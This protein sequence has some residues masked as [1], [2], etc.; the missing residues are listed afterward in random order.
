[1]GTLRT[2]LDKLKG[3]FPSFE[4]G[5]TVTLSFDPARG[6]VLT[7]KGGEI[8]VIEGKDFSDALFKV[9]LGT[10]PVDDNLMD[11]MLGK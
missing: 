4:K 7:G 2:R 11:G 3:L 9:W 1:M 5:D 8:G 10:D 6:T